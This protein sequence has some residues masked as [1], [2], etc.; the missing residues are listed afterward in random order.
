MSSP[1][2]FE[3]TWRRL[4]A[5]TV[6]LFLVIAA[7][8]AGRMRAGADPALGQGTSHAAQR[9]AAQSTPADPGILGG[10]PQG[11]GGGAQSAPVDPS[12]P[13]THAS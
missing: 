2:R 5:A 3:P 12:P 13:T 8:L 1:S 11:S 7:F 4:G 10:E 9:A 6:G